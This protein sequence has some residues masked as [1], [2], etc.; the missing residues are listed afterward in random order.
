M[1]KQFKEMMFGLLLIFVLVGALCITAVVTRNRTQI[2]WINP[3][4]YQ[5]YTIDDSIYLYDADRLVG[6]LRFDQPLD[7]LIIKDNQ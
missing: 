5:I 7:S 3:R 6:G 4:D 1:N 2:Q